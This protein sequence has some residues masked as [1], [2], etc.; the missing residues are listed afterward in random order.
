MS[1]TSPLKAENSINE[2]YRLSSDSNTNYVHCPSAPF[3]SVCMTEKEYRYLIQKS[4][5]ENKYLREKAQLN[6]NKK[7]GHF[8]LGISFLFG[9][10]LFYLVDRS[11]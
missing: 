8:D 1:I 2:V 4:T 9:A 5:I 3:D 7:F 10:T 6:I 11:R